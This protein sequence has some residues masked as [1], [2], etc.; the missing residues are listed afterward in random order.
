[1]KTAVAIAFEAEA[2]AAIVA[3]SFAF[4][5]TAGRWLAVLAWA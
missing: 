5:A 1:V 4:V 2:T 3:S